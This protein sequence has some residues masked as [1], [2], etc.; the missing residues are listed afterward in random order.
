MVTKRSNPTVHRMNFASITQDQHEAIQDNLI[1]LKSS[2]PDCEFTC[3][4]C[5]LDLQPNHIRDQFIRSLNNDTLQTDILTKAS[6][7]KTLEDVV[8]HAEAF[9]TALRDQQSL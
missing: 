9:E 7:L 2:A 3:P 6:Q 8:K 1:R 4:S 5:K